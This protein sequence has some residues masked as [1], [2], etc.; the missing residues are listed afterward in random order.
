M[1]KG[2]K[3]SAMDLMAKNLMIM[4]KSMQ[5]KMKEI[6]KHNFYKR[7]LNKKVPPEEKS[8]CLN[9]V[10]NFPFLN[11]EI[12]LFLLIFK[13]LIIIRFHFFAIFDRWP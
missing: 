3:L 9:L 1:F 8:L 4:I 13:E 12:F 11:I 7:S 2:S 10:D 5:N 6:F